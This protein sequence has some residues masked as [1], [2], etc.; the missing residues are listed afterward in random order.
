M[1]ETPERCLWKRQ[2]GFCSHLIPGQL[3]SRGA[4]GACVVSLSRTWCCPTVLCSHWSAAGPKPL[5]TL[6]FVGRRGRLVLVGNNRSTRILPGLDPSAQPGFGTTPASRSSEVPTV[7]PR[8]LFPSCAGLC[9]LWELQPPPGLI[10][11][12][13]GALIED[14]S[15]RVPSRVREKLLFGSSCHFPSSP[16]PQEQNIF[17]PGF[18]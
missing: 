9:S 14:L 15:W 11:G 12:V 16:P 17:F 5:G 13:L 4:A 6:I 3:R 2:P 8:I 18:I 10:H 7:S 1:A